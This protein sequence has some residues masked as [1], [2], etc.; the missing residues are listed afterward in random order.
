MNNTGPLDSVLSTPLG[1]GGLCGCWGGGVGN[2]T[3]I[4]GNTGSNPSK[5]PNLKPMAGGNSCHL[6]LD[7]DVTSKSN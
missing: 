6:Y 3:I 2:G 4:L 1:T 5:E 7:N